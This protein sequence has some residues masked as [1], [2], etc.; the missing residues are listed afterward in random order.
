M[1]SYDRLVLAPGLRDELAASLDEQLRGALGVFAP[2]DEREEK[3]LEE[4]VAREVAPQA[5]VRVCIAGAGVDTMIAAQRLAALGVAPARITVLCP[6][7]EFAPVPGERRAN[8]LIAHAIAEEGITVRC[9]AAV[10]SAE[11]RQQRLAGVTLEDGTVLPCGL[12]LSLGEAQGVGAALFRALNA[13][14]LVLDGRLVVDAAFKTNDPA[15]SAGG[16]LVKFARRIRDARRLEQFN[17]REA[18]RALGRA[19]LVDL[20]PDAAHVGRANAA[21]VP[22]L[23]APLG[24]AGALPAGLSLVRVWAS[25]ALFRAVG[26]GLEEDVVSVVQVAAPPPPPFVLS[27]HAASLTPY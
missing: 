1:L 15:I 23:E 9:G 27:G 6:A 26:G 5:D 13:Q 17:A 21:R 11:S 19:L 7:A 22:P 16:S 12:L 14:S 8:E 25:P 3:R 10:V 20:D 4:F 18:G 24:T 2:Q